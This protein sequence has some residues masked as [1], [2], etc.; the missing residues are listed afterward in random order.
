MKDKLIAFGSF[1][2]PGV[3]VLMVLLL[4]V[5]PSFVDMEAEVSQN[6]QIVVGVA[7]T[8]LFLCVFG[9]WS[10]IIHLFMHVVKNEQLTQGQ[11]AGWLCGLWL[12]SVFTIPLYWLRHLRP[13]DQSS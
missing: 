5:L 6:V 4:L 2:C 13:A 10:L 7:M 9:T 3:I 12:L 1:F 11:K 8:L